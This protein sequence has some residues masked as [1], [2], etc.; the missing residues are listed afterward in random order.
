M[1][2]V[3]VGRER[4][5]KNVVEETLSGGGPVIPG[6]FMSG[7]LYWPASLWDGFCCDLA[8]GRSFVFFPGGFSGVDALVGQC[9]A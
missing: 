8:L 2:H 6:H 7:V 1:I 9:I 3:P 5:I 4:N